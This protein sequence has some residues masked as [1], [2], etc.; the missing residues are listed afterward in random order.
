[1]IRLSATEP[2]QH[3]IE[4]LDEKER[5]LGRNLEKQKALYEVFFGG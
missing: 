1:M 4:E 3:Y 2:E 5:T